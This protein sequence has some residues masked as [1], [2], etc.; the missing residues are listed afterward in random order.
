MPGKA[1][2]VWMTERQ[3]PILVELSQSRT[4]SQLVVE[5]A[6]LVWRAFD[7]RLNAEIAAE[8]SLGP[9]PVGVWRRRWPAAWEELTALECREPRR[10][11]EALQ[12]VFLDA[13]RTGSPGK[14]TAKQVTQILALACEPPEKSQRPITHSRAAGIARRGAAAGNRPPDFRV[15][16][17]P[18]SET[19][20]VATASA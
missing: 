15:S 12:E 10:L 16:G 2:K 9:G 6:T 11:R 5:R 20:R 3:Q 19:G 17:G 18:L 7:G 1:A 8:I 14:F 13:P 4:E